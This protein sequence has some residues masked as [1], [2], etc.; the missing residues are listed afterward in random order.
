M[1]GWSRWKDGVDGGMEVEGW[2]W[3]KDVVDGGME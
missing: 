1:E 2:R 3:W